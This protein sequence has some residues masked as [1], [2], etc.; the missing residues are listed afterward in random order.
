M[1]APPN[2]RRDALEGRLVFAPATEMMEDFIRNGGQAMEREAELNARAGALTRRDEE[3]ME[4][5]EDAAAE[6]LAA[7]AAAGSR[8][9]E[10]GSA[11]AAAPVTIE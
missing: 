2:G 11:E 6:M 4:D 5:E 3:A 9:G 7:A 10:T 8:D 1:I